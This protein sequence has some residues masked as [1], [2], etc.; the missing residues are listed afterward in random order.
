MMSFQTSLQ[1]YGLPNSF[2]KFKKSKAC[3][4]QKK[5]SRWFWALGPIVS[6][7]MLSPYS[8]QGLFNQLTYI[9]WCKN[10]NVSAKC[11]R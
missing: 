7:A 1:A 8:L 4:L 2:I 11:V 3:L 10:T 9:S 5:M 6:I